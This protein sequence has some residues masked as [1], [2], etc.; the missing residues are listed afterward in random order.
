M[1]LSL[2]YWSWMIQI[3]TAAH[4]LF[5]VKTQ[6][7]C[8]LPRGDAKA[9]RPAGRQ[10]EKGSLTGRNWARIRRQSAAQ[11][12]GAFSHFRRFLSVVI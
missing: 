6:H 1:T 7:V 3:W 2:I 11:T 4:R 10:Q 5:A 9:V 12:N 8:K